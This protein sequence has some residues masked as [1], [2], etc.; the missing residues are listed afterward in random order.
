VL[1]WLS[2]N[3]KGD[4]VDSR[5]GGVGR[6]RVAWSDNRA[7]NKGKTNASRDDDLKPVKGSCP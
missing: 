6:P 7:T 1:S 2:V 3:Q 4:N 5:M